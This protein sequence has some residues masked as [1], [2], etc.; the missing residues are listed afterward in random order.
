MQRR[1]VGIKENSIETNHEVF[2]LDIAQYKRLSHL[3]EHLT[4]GFEDRCLYPLRSIVFYPLIGV[5]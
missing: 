2:E 1:V 5:R 3:G 4:Q